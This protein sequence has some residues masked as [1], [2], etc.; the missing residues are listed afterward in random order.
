MLTDALK[1]V[2]KQFKGNVS[3]EVLEVM[4]RSTAELAESKLVESAL[5]VGDKMPAFKLT[6]AIG[7]SIDSEVLL[8]KGPLVINFYRGGWWPY[9]NL[10]LGGYQ[11]ILDEIHGKG[12]QLVAISPELPDETLS[13]TEKLE[14][15]FEILSDSNNELAKQ[16]GIV[17]SMKEELIEIYKGFGIDI[18][19]TQ[20]NENFELPVPGTFVVDENSII[21]LAHMD[22][23]Y[24][25]RIEPEEVLTVL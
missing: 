8:S 20:G 13:T 4:E 14:L 25:T 19:G 16:F 22:V 17:F 9:C 24:T 3:T 6:N 7:E 23:D 1:A 15:Q 21:K 18:A 2:S 11:D 5:K 12:A 10:E